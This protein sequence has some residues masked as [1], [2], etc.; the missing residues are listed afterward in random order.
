MSHKAIVCSLKNVRPHNNADRLNVAVAAGH[1]VITGRNT[2]DGL[3]GLYF[4]CELQI[5]EEF[6]KANNLVR[7]KD[8]DGNNVGG[9]F[10]ENRKVKTQKLRGEIS[11]G[12]WIEITSL[13]SFGNLSVS[14][15]REGEEFDSFN[16]VLI[17]NK[18]ITPQ[19][20]RAIANRTKNA[21]KKVPV[22]V[23]F[24]ENSD[25]AHLIRCINNINNGDHIIITEK[26]HGTSVRC[27]NM[28]VRRELRWYEK[29]LSK[30]GIPIQN[31]EYQFMVGSRRVIKSLPYKGNA[32]IKHHD[33][34]LWEKACEPLHGL[35][36]KGE[37]FYGEIC[38]YETSGKPI[39]QTVSN[40]SLKDKKFV[41]K[42]GKQTTYSYGCP[43]GKFELY[44]YRITLTNEDGYTL[45]Y[46]WEDVKK[47]CEQI[48]I[49][50]VP[51]VSKPFIFGD[52][53]HVF[54]NDNE[55][56]VRDDHRWLLEEF[57]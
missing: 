54:I 29:L 45:D 35:I 23:M 20:A 51:E 13:S 57:V 42:Y 46:P 26:L 34:D 31:T 1:N 19:T 16:G 44:I 33:D 28:Q 47:R 40:E 25:T 53:G 5:S 3:L 32:V 9:L 37:Q 41:Q 30:I 52:L 4:S 14:A 24:K 27:G 43:P 50:H 7:R 11:D 17:C 39:M 55:S 36:R 38:G 15:L 6:A 12:F 21:S 22:S 10:G 49:K 48:A 56:Y 8:A 18:Y 2:Y